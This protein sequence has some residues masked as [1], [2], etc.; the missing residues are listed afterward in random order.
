MAT[1]QTAI[2]DRLAAD[3]SLTAAQPGGLGFTVFDRWLK[4][5]GPGSTPTAFD[6]AQGG[7]LRRAI[8]VLDGGEV[9]NPARQAAALRRWDSF[10]TTDI[11]AEA[12]AAGKQA[13]QDAVRRIEAL[14][15]GW[16]T[17]VGGQRVGFL[18]DSQ[19]VLEDAEA[20]PGNVRLRA[21]WRAVSARLLIPA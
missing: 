19:L 17:V 3:A 14:L 15:V 11:F 12:H 21:T 6:P 8:V 1:L 5:N 2:R 18:P 20:F 16:E 13:A 10:P 4:P 9:T 7:R